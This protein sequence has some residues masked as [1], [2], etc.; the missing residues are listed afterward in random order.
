MCT[1]LCEYDGAK[2]VALSSSAQA[3]VAR[4]ALM[5]GLVE[6]QQFV[7]LEAAMCDVRQRPCE[8]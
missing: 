4:A 7:A 6:L 3:A 8:I 2:R 5:R 1:G